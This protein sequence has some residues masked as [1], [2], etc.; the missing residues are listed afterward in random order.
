MRI[1]AGVCG[2]EFVSVKFC[3][4]FIRSLSTNKLR[5]HDH[6]IAGVEFFFARGDGRYLRDLFLGALLRYK[7]QPR[8]T[9][10]MSLRD[11][12]IFRETRS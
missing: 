9:A 7:M 6:A 1:V 2:R 11:I 10:F 5:I 4:P 12:F 8:S 3:A